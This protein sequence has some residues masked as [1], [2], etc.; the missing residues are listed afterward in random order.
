MGLDTHSLRSKKLRT[1][2][3]P[4]FRMCKGRTLTT[5]L[6][7]SILV[8]ELKATLWGK[9]GK[10]MVLAPFC[11]QEYC[12]SQGTRQVYTSIFANPYPFCLPR[13]NENFYNL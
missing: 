12:S 4:S 7:L 5:F 2:F 1:I 9:V 13:E 3:T 11:F 6:A 10:P 8:R